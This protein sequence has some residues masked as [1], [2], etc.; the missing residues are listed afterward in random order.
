[1]LDASTQNILEE[2]GLGEK[3]T[4]AKRSAG[5]KRRKNGQKTAISGQKIEFFQEKS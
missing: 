5:R 3:K 2:T 4:L 1:M